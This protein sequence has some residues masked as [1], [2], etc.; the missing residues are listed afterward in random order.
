ML[1]HSTLVLY[2]HPAPHRSLVHRHLA[3][4]ARGAAGVHVQDLYETY[5]DFDIDGDRER[6]LLAPAQLIVF[7]HPF[8]WYGMP[9]LM[10][11]WMDVVLQ[12]GWAYGDGP[13]ALRGKTLWLVTTTGSGSD[14]YR[15]DGLHGRPFGDFLAPYE[16]AAALCGMAWRMPLVLHGATG[17]DAAT[18]ADHAATFA[19]GLVAHASNVAHAGDPDGT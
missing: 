1:D 8:R 12:P 14:A 15:P 4:A 7:L 17:L 10:K 9:S 6:A 11:E 2:A 16:Q 19:R 5:P 18:A 3:D 13:N